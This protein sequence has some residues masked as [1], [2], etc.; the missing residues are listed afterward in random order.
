MRNIL[1]F[2]ISFLLVGCQQ[3]QTGAAVNTTEDDT[4]ITDEEVIEDDITIYTE[5]DLEAAK[6]EAF[7]EGYDEGYSIGNDEGYEAGYSDAIDVATVE[8]NNQAT[9]PSLSNGSSSRYSSS[10]N[11]SSDG[12]EWNIAL[13]YEK[14]EFVRAVLEA[15]GQFVTFSDVNDYILAIDIYYENNLKLNTLQEALQSLR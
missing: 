15:N 11:L 5:E 7:Q 3:E 9:V 4:T 13:D 10:L 6:E 12:M 14:K 1:L 8:Y 2:F